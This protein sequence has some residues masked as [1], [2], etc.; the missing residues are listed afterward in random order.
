[1]KFVK[2]KL[3]ANMKDYIKVNEN[4]VYMLIIS[5]I[6]ILIFFYLGFFTGF[7]KSPYNHD[8]ISILKNLT[9]KLLPII[10]IEITRAI[11]LNINKKNKKIAVII[12]IL[13]ILLEIDYNTIA[14]IYTDKKLVFEYI[15]ES[16]IPMVMYSGL[17][18]Y[19]TI[20]DSC[21]LTLIFRIIKQTSMLIFPILPNMNWFIN[22][23]MN[24]I[25]ATIIYILFQYRLGKGDKKSNIIS[26]IS[27]GT[28]IAICVILV[29]F[30]LGCFKY[31]PITILSNSMN[32][33][34]N[35]ADVVIYKKLDELEKQEISK[36][37]IIVYSYEGK[38]IVHRV[39]D[40][41]NENGATKYKTKGDRNNVEDKNLV[42]E[43]QIKGIVTFTIRY[44]GYPSVWLYE[45]FNSVK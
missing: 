1:M 42:G 9:I 23:S 18:T 11:L 33:Q 38:N 21:L 28:V 22:G 14:N 2:N 3:L 25:T 39:V 19:L 4:C 37:S 32:P 41:V 24:A 44:I 31:E 5:V 20:K 6:Y 26:K 17:Y 30:M 12:T 43:E 13:L 27:Y 15:C 16:L 36:G 34:I 35:R 8:I 40:T 45:Y 7:A 29:C 10:G